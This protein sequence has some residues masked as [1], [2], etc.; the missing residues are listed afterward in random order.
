MSTEADWGNAEFVP[1][2]NP[3][4]RQ[5]TTTKQPH[6][7]ERDT[8]TTPTAIRA[9]VRIRPYFPLISIK[10]L[11]ATKKPYQPATYP[12]NTCPTP[13]TL[14]LHQLPARPQKELI[15]QPL[16]PRTRTLTARYS[17]DQDHP[18]NPPEQ[19]TNKANLCDYS[20]VRTGA[21]TVAT[22]ACNIA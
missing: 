20:P 4:H 13:Y 9:L 17:I 1:S 8:K 5:S 12:L 14:P 2:L 15:H 10:Y 6:A 21:N 19:T 22:V 18:L 11:I 16:T 3:N 7:H